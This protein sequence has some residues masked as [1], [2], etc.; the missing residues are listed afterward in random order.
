MKAKQTL[1]TIGLIAVTIFVVRQ[2]EDEPKVITKIEYVTKTDTI[3]SVKIVDKPILRYV[4]R[5]KTIKGKDSIIYVD[6]PTQNDSTVIQAKEYDAVVKTDSSRAD[7]KIL[8]T[9]ELLNVSGTISY[10]QKQTTTK[11]IKP[12]SGLFMYVESSIKPTFERVE[13][14][15]DYQLRNKII[16]GTSVSYNNQV[17]KVYIGAKI[18]FK[19]L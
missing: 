5:I 7:L 18:G 15:L 1:I 13:L 14:G 19:I 17:K 2:C 16:L 10:D 8:T 9:G 6:K 3:K 4:E 11:I 12:K